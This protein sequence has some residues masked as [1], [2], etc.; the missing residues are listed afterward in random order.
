[1]HLYPDGDEGRGGGIRAGE[2]DDLMARAD[3][4][5]DDGGADPAGCAGN[6]NFHRKFLQ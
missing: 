5:R 3:E 2:A 6:E 1:M 4:L